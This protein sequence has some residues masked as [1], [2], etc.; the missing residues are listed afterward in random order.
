LLGAIHAP[1]LMSL[2]FVSAENVRCIEKA[3][4]ELHGGQ[5]L[6]VG[7][8]GSGKTSLLEAIFLL[9]RGRSFRTRH[10]E[11]LIRHG[12]DE[13]IVFGR[14]R[15]DPERTLGV[16]CK[17]GTP[18]VAKVGGVFADSLAELSEAFPVQ[19]IDPGVHK[20]IEESALRRRRWLDWVV[21][22]VEHGFVDLWT[23]YRRTLQQRNAALR[24]DLAQAATWEPELSRLGE[25]LGESRRRVLE[26]LQP[27]WSDTVRALA[28]GD[29]EL[30]YSPGW[31]RGTTLA[32]ALRSSRS[33]D[34][35]RGVT[36]CGPHRCDVHVRIDGVAARQVVSRGQQ[37]LIAAAMI[38]AQLRMLRK[39][40]AAAPTLLLDDPA[41]ELDAAHL[42][43]FIE[44]VMRLGCQLVLASLSSD[45]SIFGSTDR[46]FHVE[47]GRVR[48]V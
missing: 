14:T 11:R 21:F 13:L 36:Q 45:R 2:A 15:G 9:G 41:A 24:G 39:E 6:L 38:L 32:E 33:R 8:N 37:K 31:P 3:A 35:A 40:F 46:M 19:V 18:T 27:Y 43:A 22:H 26:R 23:R 44:Q 25:A 1:T 17:R 16:R 4:L 28:E 5:N 30:K 29:V 7:P 34:L 48:P 47:Q 12:Q 42:S 10:T 20:L